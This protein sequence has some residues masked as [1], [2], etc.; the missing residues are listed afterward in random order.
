MMLILVACF[1]PPAILFVSAVSIMRAEI[2]KNRE[3]F[4]VL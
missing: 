2:K 3:L 1:T 4:N